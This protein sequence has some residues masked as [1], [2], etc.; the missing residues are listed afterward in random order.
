MDDRDDPDDAS[1][2]GTTAESGTE[3]SDI[4]GA[5][6]E[7][8]PDWWERN[9]RQKAEMDLPP[10]EP[11]RFADGTYTHEVVEPLES[12]YD[13]SIWFVGVDPS[14]PDEWE[15]RVDGDPVFTVGRHRDG[16]G[17]TVYEMPAR[18]FRERLETYLLV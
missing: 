6:S 2:D 3:A 5:S 16:D 10:Y 14:Y 8:R 15:V 12:A 11:P 1:E 9:R 4:D 18:E 7:D 13:C 17:N